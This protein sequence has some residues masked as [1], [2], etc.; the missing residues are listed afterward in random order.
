MASEPVV[1]GRYQLEREIGRGGM[2]VV[3]LATDTALDQPVAL[4]RVSLGGLDDEQAGQIRDRALQEARMAAQLRGH[5]HVVTVYDVVADERDVWLVCEYV[6]SQ[7][8]ARILAARKR[9]DPGEAAHIGAGIADALAAAHASGIVHRDVTPGNVLIGSDG[10]VKLTDFG[11]SRL[12]NDPRV[13]ATGAVNGTIAYLAP[14]V[15][16][17]GESTP[18]S[19]VYS[20]GST[21]YTAV[22]GLP[23]FGN[24]D[25]AIKLLNV[26]RTG[27]IRPPEHA[28]ALTPLLLRLL[29]LDPNTR[30]DAETAREKLNQF[31]TGLSATTTRITPDQQVEPPGNGTTGPPVE[32]PTERIPR[33]S[34]P[35]RRRRTLLAA[36]AA[37]LVTAVVLALVL[38][39]PDPG[40]PGVATP[41]AT[42]ATANGV[43]Q[44]PRTAPRLAVGDDVQTVSL[45]PLVDPAAL[46]QFGA[47]T[48]QRGEKLGGCNIDISPVDGSEG[49]EVNLLVDYQ[50]DS[51]EEVDG[52]R[53]DIG[54][55]KMFRGS[56][57]DEDTCQDH[58]GLTDRTL[59]KIDVYQ[60]PPPTVDP[61]RVA[62]VISNEALV[63]LA[64]RGIPRDPSV[65][66]YGL[67][68]KDAC[69][70]IG[71][72]SLRRVPGLKVDERLERIDE[73]YCQWGVEEPGHTSLRLDF[74]LSV[75]S[76]EGDLAETPTKV[77]GRPAYYESYEG[78]LNPQAC[79]VDVVTRR[80]STAAER[81]EFMFL[82]LDGPGSGKQLCDS[83]LRLADVATRNA[84]R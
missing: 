65:L 76:D 22:E 18:E 57:V 82:R 53:T 60:E 62:K 21:L 11:I 26:V 80:A 5:P 3:W 6:P 42:A 17:T 23:P 35:G 58:I 9:I 33:P 56:Y 19:D 46:R 73:W 59:I 14:E 20:L 54:G 29:E 67:A 25:N 10:R 48:V 16:N 50:A 24:T 27:I 44:L 81:T 15:A 34:G 52:E 84:V 38:L 1:L 13:T 45:C 77:A 8:L 32:A 66:R 61:C 68:R 83:A 63:R 74:Q 39:L 79:E 12:A 47:V 4:K 51:W 64:E 69:D 37:A 75:E 49:P 43:P 40:T 71:D 7:S 31:A 41:G 36:G 55:L 78:P 72:A 30:P 70:M 28:G 2:G